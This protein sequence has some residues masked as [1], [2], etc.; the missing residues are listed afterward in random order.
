MATLLEM[1][2]QAMRRADARV[3]ASDLPAP[4]RKYLGDLYSRM[5][6]GTDPIRGNAPGY[7]RTVEEA[8]GMPRAG[9]GVRA[10]AERMQSPEA[11]QT[12]L[13]MALTFG[14]PSGRANASNDIERVYRA[15][16]DNDPYAKYGLRVIPKGYEVKT[17]DVL[18][19][20]YRWID[21]EMTDE[22]LP[23]VSTIGIDNS[24]VETALKRLQKGGYFGDQI[25]LIKGESMGAGEDPYEVLISMPEVIKAWMR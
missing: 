20:S 4:I 16:K 11:R 25:A 14:I 13:N 8:T 23:G 1:Y 21:G 24:G 2:A 3:R 15:A 10:Y 22:L 18:P 17:G 6:A 9:E 5:S 12:L 19:H 7:Q